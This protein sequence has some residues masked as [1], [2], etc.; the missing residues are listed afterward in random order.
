MNPPY[1]L[2]PAIRTQLQQRCRLWIV[3]DDNFRLLK[4][5][6]KCA[7]ILY[8]DIHIGFPVFWCQRHGITLQSVVDRLGDREKII[9][10]FDYLPGTCQ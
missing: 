1:P 2:A 4:R 10:P 6:L 9:R 5:F 3:D 7:E 8:I